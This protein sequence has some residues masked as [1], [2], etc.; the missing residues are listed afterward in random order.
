[1]AKKIRFESFVYRFLIAAERVALALP[2]QESKVMS[3]FVKQLTFQYKAGSAIVSW[4]ANP[5][6]VDFPLTDPE[7]YVRGDRPPVDG[8][9]TERTLVDPVMARNER[10]FG[11]AF[12]RVT[13]AAGL[14]LDD[15]IAHDTTRAAEA[16]TDARLLREEGFHDAWAGAD[17]S[18]ADS[19]VAACEAS[20]SPEMRFIRATLGDLQGKTLLDIGCGLGEASVYF[21]LKGAD[22][23]SLDISQGMLDATQKLAHSNNVHVRTHKAAAE[24]LELLPEQYFDIIYAGNLLHHV[25]IQQTLR[26]V[27]PHL[28]P[29]GVFVSWDP[30]AY[31]PIINLYRMIAT[32]V[33]T[34]DEHP[35]R[36]SDIRLI[37]SEFQ[38]V[39]TR[40]FWFSTL[41]IFIWMVVAQRRN[42]NRERFWKSVV[43]ESNRWD[44]WYLPLSRLDG[45]LLRNFP[46]LRWLCW[47]VVVIARARPAPQAN[48]TD[49]R[50]KTGSS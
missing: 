36:A 25:D 29:E 31:N 6:G 41:L 45:F 9:S 28:A 27:S 35:L 13:N 10:V 17:N 39:K 19:I 46:P 4:T 22:V 50:P 7:F 42:P 20:T 5:E 2:D 14:N 15:P 43:A 12:R 23:T 33:R 37:E 26:L 47:N 48:S 16:A 40:F 11:D 18:G 1:M 32:D 24:R 49:Y 38:D 21:A 44:R 8:Q 3:L 34:A 30:V